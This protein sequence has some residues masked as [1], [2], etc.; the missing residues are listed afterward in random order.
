VFNWSDRKEDIEVPRER[1]GWGEGLIVHSFWDDAL[2]ELRGE[3]LQLRGI[4]PHGCRLLAAFSRAKTASWVGST[5]HV[6]QGREVESWTTQRGTAAFRVGLGR[7]AEGK[8]LLAIPARRAE[9]QIDG[10]SLRGQE[11]G[12]GIWEFDLSLEQPAD[13]RVWYE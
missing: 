4:E 1:L 3:G 11:R 2:Y 6:S 5:L 7:K 12:L 13:L 8:V 10:R 9:A